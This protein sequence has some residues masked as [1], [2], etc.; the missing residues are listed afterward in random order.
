M[1]IKNVLLAVFI[2]ITQINQSLYS[3]LAPSAPID[4]SYTIDEKHI[5]QLKPGE[6]IQSLESKS[7]NIE[8]LNT[9]KQAL[10][11]DT[12]TLKKTIDEYKNTNFIA[13]SDR[14]K[15]YAEENKVAKVIVSN[16][17]P[18]TKKVELKNYSTLNTMPY[19]FPALRYYFLPFKKAFYPKSDRSVATI[20]DIKDA[21][22]SYELT[23]EGSEGSR[24]TYKNI[25]ASAHILITNIKMA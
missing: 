14:L 21:T 25:P 6:K 23:W 5:I 12:D 7:R 13:D 20:S 19:G 2:T 1:K 11:D 10:E 24:G 3:Y 17:N 9:L 8:N 4:I 16:Y 22:D 15:K 18:Q